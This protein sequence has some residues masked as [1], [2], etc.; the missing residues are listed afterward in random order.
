M[1]YKPSVYFKDLRV[2]QRDLKK[3]IIVD[4]AP[5]AFASQVENGYPII[6]FYDSKEDEEMTSLTKY[7]LELTTVE[8]IRIENRKKFK[9]AE[10]MKTSIEQYLRFYHR[11]NSDA[12][13]QA[14]Q[15]SSGESSPSVAEG[16]RADLKKIQDEMANIKLAQEHNK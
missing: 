6:P 8:D 11:V 3:V 13:G 14:E 15:T 1:Q 7:L 9:L 12:A 4:N 16:I 2:I 10:L 5:Y